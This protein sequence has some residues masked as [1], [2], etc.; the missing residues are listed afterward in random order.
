MKK[1]LKFILAA[2]LIIS[3]YFIF[4]KKMIS[5]SSLDLSVSIEVIQIMEEYN[6]KIE[7]S[8][9]GEEYKSSDHYS[10]YNIYTREYGEDI[11]KDEIKLR[12]IIKDDLKKYYWI[13]Y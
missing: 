6:K 10:L 1:N 5:E 7:A 9:N 13:I 2:I 3:I 8:N 12:H 4:K 11:C